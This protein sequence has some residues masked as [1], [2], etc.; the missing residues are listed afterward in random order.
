VLLAIAVIDFFSS[1]NSMGGP[2]KLFFLGFIGIPMLAVGSFMV[3]AGYLREIT[4]YTAEESSP[5]ISTVAR[6]AR[7]GWTDGAPENAADSGPRLFCS[8]CGVKNDL[9]AKF[10]DSCG[11]KL[12]RPA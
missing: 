3:K 5:A 4:E 11:A 2:P 7:E 8:S 12:S 1:F 10:C 9:D 6:A